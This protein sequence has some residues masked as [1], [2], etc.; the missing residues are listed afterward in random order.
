MLGDMGTASAGHCAVPA[1]GSFWPRARDG[2]ARLSDSAAG[3]QECKQSATAQ[4]RIMVTNASSDFPTLANRRQQKRS[5]TLP[6]TSVPASPSKTA[7][8][9]SETP[10]PLGGSYAGGGRPNPSHEHPN[11]T[12]YVQARTRAHMP[13]PSPRESGLQQAPPRNC[14]RAKIR[15]RHARAQESASET[16]PGPRTVRQHP[17][18]GQQG[19]AP[20]HACRP[21]SRTPHAL[22]AVARLTRAVR[23]RLKK[24]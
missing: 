8:P 20:P 9:R 2:G 7:L 14:A 17:G 11:G 5:V 4:Y 13:G 6:C 24:T 23:R 21:L 16:W 18:H 1:C 22:A 19:G 3:G 12:R 15:G 10:W